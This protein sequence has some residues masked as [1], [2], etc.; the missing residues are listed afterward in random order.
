MLRSL[1]IGEGK[2]AYLRRGGMLRALG[3][4]PVSIALGFVIMVAVGCMLGI[5]HTVTVDTT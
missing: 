5:W 3:S 4:A 2:L 1:L